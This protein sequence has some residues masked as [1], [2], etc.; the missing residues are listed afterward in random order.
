M[1]TYNFDELTD[2]AGT[3]SLKWDVQDNEL[4]MWVADMDFPAAPVVMNALQ[5]RLENGVFGYT[6]VLDEF[7]AAIQTWWSKRH[8]W[9][10]QAD[11]VVFATGVIPAISS[12][13]RKFTALNDNILVQPPVYN[14]FYSTITSNGRNALESALV[15]AE[16]AYTVDWV[17]LEQKLANPQ[18]KLMLL[19]NPQNPSGR[20]WALDELQ[21][22]A[23]LCK[24]YQV[25]VISDEI[26]CD[27]TDP[28][29]EYEPFA[30]AAAAE[31]FDD[32]LVCIS[33]SKPFNLAGLQC[34]AVIVPRAD[35]RQEAVQALNTDGIAEPNAFAM[36]GAEAAYSQEGAKWL[37]E[38]R[39][40]IAE[41]K[42][43]A[44]NYIR[45]QIPQITAVYGPATYLMWLDCS[46]V[47]G[48]QGNATEL[49]DFLRAKTG[50]YL[51]EGECYGSGGKQFMRLNLATQ[52]S[53]VED[54][55][56]RLRRGVEEYLSR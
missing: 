41:N 16:G 52:R 23:R 40:Y 24:Q 31:Q 47:V 36:A 38:L 15:Y 18:T 9:N 48:A 19:C 3:Y 10:L 32:Y 8:A 26:H 50:L 53:R 14:M 27:L 21:K 42:Q 43:F 49:R 44:L 12:L 35:L 34:A 6:I 45:E 25:R 11:W 55:M 51:S 5:K 54:G 28:G 4:P 29:E 30:L 13:I 46:K 39:A 56:Q 7:R 22:I 17:D 33:P 1:N 37:D 2:R 20:I